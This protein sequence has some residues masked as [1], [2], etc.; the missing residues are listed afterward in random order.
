MLRYIL[1]RLLQFIPVFLGVTLLLFF[2]QYHMPGVDQAQMRMG[3]RAVTPEFRAA[4]EEAH[5]FDRPWYEQYVMYLGNLTQGDLGRSYMSGRAV[6]DT[7]IDR[8]PYTLRLALVAIALQAILGIGAGI[9]SAV[10][11]RSFWDVLVTMSTS[12]AVSLPVFWLGLIL[13]YV[14][15]IWLQNATGGA[16]FLP[17][18]GA[19]GAL[20]TWTYYV[21][22]GFTLAVVS[23]AYTARIMRSQLLEVGNA[24]Y[25]RTAKAKGCSPARILWGHK[26]KNALIPVITAMGVDFGVMLAGAI[27]TETV[28]NWPGIGLLIS[29]AIMQRDFQ[30]IIGATTVILFIVMIISL[31]VD[32]A[33]GFL[34][35]RIRIAGGEE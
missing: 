14:F 23:M 6:A 17:V 1:K 24:D 21:M 35:P 7:L 34:D 33:Y 5:G 10:K 16:F 20:P 30:V 26:M 18:T 2:I 15:G 27:F 25:V 8:Y 28:F 13:Q 11:R 32:I 4:F 22:P 19:R 12:I 9:V 29:T 3:E 31:V